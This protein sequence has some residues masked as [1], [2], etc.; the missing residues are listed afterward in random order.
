L[1][2]PNTGKRQNAAYQLF[3]VKD[4]GA[5]FLFVNTHL[6]TGTTYAG[7]KAR[8]QET[9]TM[10]KKAKA[11]ASNHG[12]TSVVYVGD[13]NSYFGEWDVVDLT[14]RTMRNA[15]VPDTLEVATSRY[16]SVYDSINGLFRV[17]R[18]GHGSIDHIYASGGI[19]VKGWGELLRISDGKFVGTIPSDHNPIYASLAIPY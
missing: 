8:G 1:I 5:R 11:Y 19:G 13:F 3:R 10:L 7:D 18:H 16:R 6:I 2:D 14:G 9:A 4:T 12:V 15:H 17:A